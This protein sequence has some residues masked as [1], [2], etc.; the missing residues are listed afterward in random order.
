MM[1]FGDAL[2]KMF[3]LS[4]DHFSTELEV[5]D[6]SQRS[7]L[8]IQTDFDVECTFPEHPESPISLRYL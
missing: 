7:R 8:T 4:E 3:D 2:F 5:N 6:S 1:S